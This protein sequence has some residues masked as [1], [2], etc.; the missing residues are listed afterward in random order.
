VVT[1]RDT[2]GFRQVQST[3][4][5]ATQKGR[6]SAMF[7]FHVAVTQSYVYFDLKC[8][9]EWYFSGTTNTRHADGLAPASPTFRWRFCRPCDVTRSDVSSAVNIWVVTSALK[10]AC[11]LRHKQE[12]GLERAV[13][14][15]SDS[16]NWPAYC[17]TNRREAW[18]ELLK[19][20]ATAATGLR[21]A[22][23]TGER[24]GVSC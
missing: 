23:Q 6:H 19:L 1:S 17:D 16:C 22:T 12:R 14:T 18:S 2:P 3:S 15:G 20:V 7:R 24:P 9:C 8:H 4:V 11:V 13:E 21:T 10:L 5:L